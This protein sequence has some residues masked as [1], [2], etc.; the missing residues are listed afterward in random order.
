MQTK[1]A[2]YAKKSEFETQLEEALQENDLLSESFQAASAALL[3]LRAEDEGFRPLNK[4]KEDEG[5]SLESLQEIAELAELQTTGNPLLIR[6]INLRASNV[7]G[8]GINFQGDVKPRFKSIMDKPINKRTLFTEG[9]FKRNERSL[10]TTGNLFMAY[11]RTSRTFF[12]IPFSEISNSA[13]NPDVVDDVWYYQRT[14]TETDLSKGI[15]NSKPTSKWYP[16]L[17]KFEE[18]DL[19]K[20]IG[21]V[22]VDADVV[23]IDLKVN[24]TIGKVWGVPDVLPAMPYAWAHAE[25]IRDASKLLKALSTIAWKVVSK[26]KANAATAAAKSALPK[27]AAGTATMTE[28]TDLTAMPRSGQVNMGDG[29]TIASYV[30]AALEVSVIALLADPGSASG[31]YGAAATLDGPTASAARSR[32][33]L[34]IEFYER[35]YRAVGE[36]SVLVN[37]PKIAEDPVY[38]IAQTLQIGFAFGAIHQDEFRAS[39]LEAT[40]VL[41]LHDEVPEPTPFTSAAQFSAEA[42]AQAEREEQVAADA[43]KAA[44]NVQGQGRSDGVGAS[45]GNNDLRDSSATPGTGS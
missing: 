3:A 7:F 40:D 32:Q 45:A 24:T 6:G 35:V 11:R 27:G 1:L 13:S 41:P 22:E 30:A 34:W 8:K 43:A 18:G 36:K 19:L 21:D 14:W 16:V 10:Y 33:N 39:F 5:F 42:Q 15:P 23:I 2:G 4:L 17:E 12:A 25:Y 31:S 9:A 26:S 38:R 44:A 28:G 29:Q 37:F 20:K